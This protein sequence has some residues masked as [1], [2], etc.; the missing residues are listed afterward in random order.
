MNYLA[1]ARVLA[2]AWKRHHPDTPFYVL[3]ID[4]MEPGVLKE[5]FAV[6]SPIDLG[7][8]VAEVH[9]RAGIYG[10]GELATSLKPHLLRYALEHGAEAAVYVDPDSDL[11]A[12][13]TDIGITASTHEI[14]LTPHFLRPVPLD[15]YYPSEILQLRFGVYNSGL[16]AVSPS[17]IPFLSWWAARLTRNCL[18]DDQAGL[19]SD[20]RWLDFV[21]AYFRCAIVDDPTVHVAHWNLHER[22]LDV[23]NGGFSVDGAPLRHVHFSAFDPDQPSRL[24]RYSPGPLRAGIRENPV[25][26]RLYEEYA[27]KIIA[28]G[29]R[30]STRLPYGFGLTASGKKYGPT[31]RRTYLPWVIEAETKGTALP[32]DPFDAA[33]SREFERLVRRSRARAAVKRV[34]PRPVRRAVR[35]IWPPSGHAQLDGRR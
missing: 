17:A 31:E 19:H 30:E 7:L 14:A 12:D 35:R 8:D 2:A 29:Y 20:Q 34:T 5:E 32:P 33:Q 9:I 1:F 23:T 4:V 22:H 25:V 11:F 26:V 18:M 27:A 13:I 15:G 24:S 10:P 3:V 16:I 28:A 6:V 21:P